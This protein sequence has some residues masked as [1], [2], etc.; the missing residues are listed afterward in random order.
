ML[1]QSLLLFLLLIPAVSG[2]ETR[3]GSWS[4][5]FKSPLSYDSVA[6]DSTRRDRK[7]V[8]NRRKADKIVD[9]REAARARNI[10]ARKKRMKA[11]GIAE[12]KDDDD[13]TATHNGECTTL[14]FGCLQHAC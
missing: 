13:G 3:M 10:A 2:I 1:K 9:A 8:S 4:S 7:L 12:K 5:P 14:F 11:W 6:G